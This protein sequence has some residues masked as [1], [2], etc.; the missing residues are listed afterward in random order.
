MSSHIVSELLKNR[1]FSSV[2][3]FVDKT[4]RDR[5][6]KI[7]II[8]DELVQRKVLTQLADSLG[9]EGTNDC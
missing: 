4:F 3:A 7:L 1:S 9:I 2:D 8:D 6:V 5:K